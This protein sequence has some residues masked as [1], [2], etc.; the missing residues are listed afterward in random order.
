MTDGQILLKMEFLPRVQILF[1]HH[2]CQPPIR[3]QHTG[4]NLYQPACSAGH[5]ALDSSSLSQH[6]VP[7]LIFREVLFQTW[8]R[9]CPL[10]G[11]LPFVFSILINHSLACTP[12]FSRWWTGGCE[13][14]G[15]TGHRTWKSSPS[16]RE[17]INHESQHDITFFSLECICT[18][19]CTTQVSQVD[20][21]AVGEQRIRRTGRENKTE[22][23]KKNGSLWSNKLCSSFQPECFWSGFLLF[24][25]FELV[26]STLMLNSCQKNQEQQSV[27]CLEARPAIQ[28][29]KLQSHG[30]KCVCIGAGLE[31]KGV[32]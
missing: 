3:G 2:G 10:L 31:R 30:D 9:L 18:E 22:R 12:L 8:P 1:F 23:K 20:L 13:C 28:Q 5:A 24:V 32:F 29:K 14:W 15:S 4:M 19:C 6:S 26:S 7:F 11:F 21:W 27:R 25:M 16:L 17:C